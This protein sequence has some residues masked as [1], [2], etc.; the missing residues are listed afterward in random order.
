MNIRPFQSLTEWVSERRAFRDAEPFTE[1]E[2]A[3]LH[4]VKAEAKAVRRHRARRRIALQ[5]RD[6]EW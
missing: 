2:L 1:A 3:L 5:Q 6:S 4:G